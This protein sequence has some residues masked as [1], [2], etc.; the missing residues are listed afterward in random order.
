MDAPWGVCAAER[1]YRERQA[2]GASSFD[3]TDGRFNLKL[4]WFAG[5]DWGSQ[6][7]QACVLDA[8]GELLGE[9]ESEHGGA[10]L[11]QMAD[12]LLSFGAADESE[13][14]VAVETPS[15]PG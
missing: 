13:I 10:G 6:K 4:A 12:W 11:L 1:Q 2:S 8:A 3:S 9:R 15:G 5:V 14:G 7:H